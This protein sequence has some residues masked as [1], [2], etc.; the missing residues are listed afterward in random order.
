MNIKKYKDL[1]LEINLNKL[2]IRSL[3]SIDISNRYLDWMNDKEIVKFTEQKHMK[4]TFK[5]IEKYVIEKYNSNFD[6]LFGIFYQSNHIGN[7]KLGPI[8]FCHKVSDI[9]FFIGEKKYMGH[10][11]MTKVID[12][13][14]N[15][16]FNQ[17]NLEKITAG[18][19]SNNLSSRK[20]LLKCG[21]E[22]EGIRKKQIIYDKKRIDALMF[23]ILKK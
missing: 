18:C 5:D 22:I 17:L 10:G 16:S 8:N 12:Y 3:K 9:S 21:F 20:V 19:Y 1:P 15:F 11:I 2:F 7:I 4:H 14:V 6:L 23:G 13:L